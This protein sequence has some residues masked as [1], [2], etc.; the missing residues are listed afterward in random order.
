[1]HINMF[2][3]CLRTDEELRQIA[4]D[5][6]T[7]LGLP[8]L[9]LVMVSSIFFAH[10]P[11]S[12]DP[13]G[14]RYL[15]IVKSAQNEDNAA[16]SMRFI[17]LSFSCRILACSSVSTR[18]IVPIGVIGSGSCGYSKSKHIE[19]SAMF[20]SASGGIVSSISKS[21]MSISGSLTSSSREGS[22]SSED[23]PPSRP[24]SHDLLIQRRSSVSLRIR[25][26]GR[27]SPMPLSS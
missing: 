16:C 27:L 6:Q 5:L 14:G 4:L 21:A 11:L 9:I 22:T 17:I 12:F 24:V 19:G 2:S 15:F 23:N 7:A 25:A 18:C 1:M 10:V 26:C 8:C 3:C 13:G 20:L